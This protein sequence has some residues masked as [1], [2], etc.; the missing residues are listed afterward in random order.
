MT[1]AART[2]GEWFPVGRGSTGVRSVAREETSMNR[3][4]V[5]LTLFGI[6]LSL[7]GGSAQAAQPPR[8]HE[9]LF[10]AL[11][12]LREARQYLDRTNRHEKVEMAH[13]ALREA[14]KYVKES[15]EERFGGRRERLVERLDHL[16]KQLE[17]DH[18]RAREALDEAIEDIE[19]A[20]KH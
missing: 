17:R 3:R 4:T 1:D 12:Q 15:R 8:R 11:E 13:R 7:L 5:V 20:V 19:F 16:D 18:T 9:P 2:C 10:K 6:G 14:I